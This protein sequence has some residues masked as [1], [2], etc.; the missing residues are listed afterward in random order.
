[1]IHSDEFPKENPSELI[2]NYEHTLLT[3]INSEGR[4]S[5]GATLVY[6]SFNLF[7]SSPGVSRVSGIT[8]QYHITPKRQTKNRT[9]AI[10]CTPLPGAKRVLYTFRFPSPSTR[11]EFPAR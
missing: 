11:Y 10:T 1:M 6:N 7:S 8:L 3:L 9:V 4:I 2:Y 5:R